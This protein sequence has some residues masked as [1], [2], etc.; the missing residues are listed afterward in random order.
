VETQVVLD[1]P[2]SQLDSLDSNSCH[3]DAME[4]DSEEKARKRNVDKL[5]K[6]QRSVLQVDASLTA[7]GWIQDSLQDGHASDEEDLTF[8]DL[9][10]FE[11]VSYVSQQDDY[12]RQPLPVE[13]HFPEARPGNAAGFGEIQEA[14]VFQP[15]P[16]VRRTLPPDIEQY[17]DTI[18]PDDGRLVKVSSRRNASGHRV[19]MRLDLG[20]TRQMFEDDAT[21]RSVGVS[22]KVF[23]V[24][25]VELGTET[26]LGPERM[27]CCGRWPLGENAGQGVHSVHRWRDCPRVKNQR[28]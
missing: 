22:R 6:M 17:L 8:E 16:R 9:S 19:G 28:R 11:G 3:I 7:G 2:F 26:S 15:A 24:T 14:I 10:T 25:Q 1:N 13:C 18:A 27:C 12:V 20:L 21:V 4:Q 5:R 23:C